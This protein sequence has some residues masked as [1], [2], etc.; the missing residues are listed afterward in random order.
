MPTLSATPTARSYRL[1]AL[2]FLLA[3]MMLAPA[4]MAG[5]WSHWRGPHQN[6]VSDETGLI[7]TWSRDG[8]NLAWRND[9]EGR[10]TPVVVDGR[11]CANGRI[12][13]DITRQETVACWDVETGELLWQRS[14]NVYLTFVP[15]NRV[16]WGDLAADPETGNVFLQF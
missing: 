5:E 15:W 6:G 13:E 9:F 12:G 2:I 3:A 10:S 11:V 7:D 4:V 8:E 16:G 14:F 1:Q